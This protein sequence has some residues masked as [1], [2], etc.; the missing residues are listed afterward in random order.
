MIIGTCNIVRA[1]IRLKETGQHRACDWSDPI[2]YIEIDG[3]YYEKKWVQSVVPVQ[4]EQLMF[5]DKKFEID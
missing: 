4:R 2:E 3:K 5:M 1:R